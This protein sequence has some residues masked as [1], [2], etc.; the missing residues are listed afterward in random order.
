MY[1]FLTGDTQKFIPPKNM[2]GYYKE[3]V[4]QKNSE[5]MTA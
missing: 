4:V 3:T 2:Q 1:C 5:H